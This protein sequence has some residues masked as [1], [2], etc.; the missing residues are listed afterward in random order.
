MMLNLSNITLNISNFNYT[1]ITNPTQAYYTCLF[2]SHIHFILFFLGFVVYSFLVIS[3]I[4]RLLKCAEINYRIDYGEII[5]SFSVVLFFAFMQ[6][7]D[8]KFIIVNFVLILWMM[9]T[10]Y[11]LGKTKT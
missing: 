8:F 9:I 5:F 7:M 1:Y 3:L 6:N 4:N 10:D 2:Q 11:L